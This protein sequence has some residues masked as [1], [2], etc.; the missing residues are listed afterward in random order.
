MRKNRDLCLDG[1]HPCISI[2]LRYKTSLY[3]EVFIQKHTPFCQMIVPF[4]TKSFS[5]GVYYYIR[6]VLN[7]ILTGSLL[8][9]VRLRRSQLLF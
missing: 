8:V 3:K 1:T 9:F 4:T 2:L 7:T 6:D 5:V